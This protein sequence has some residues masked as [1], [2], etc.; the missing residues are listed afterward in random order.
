MNTFTKDGSTLNRYDFFD[1]DDINQKSV[2]GS[3]LKNAALVGSMFL[4]Y[5]GPYVIAASVLT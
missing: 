4:P 5:V 3:I 2:G 1:S